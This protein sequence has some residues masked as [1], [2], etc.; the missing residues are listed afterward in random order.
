MLQ[1]DLPSLDF[2]AGLIDG[3]GAFMW[4]KQNG[5]ETPVFQLKM[6]A[7]EHA[8]FDMIK[9]KLG[10]KENIHE[11][12]HQGRHYVLLLIRKRATIENTIIPTFDGRLFGYKKILFEEWKKKFYE[13]KL[14]FMYKYHAK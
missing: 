11:Y 6:H 14:E 1:S 4:T 13:K 10:L 9:V 12:T 3:E 7:R 5:T 8:L 2:I